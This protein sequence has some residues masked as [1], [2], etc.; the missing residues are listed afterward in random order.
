MTLVALASVVESISGRST[1]EKQLMRAVEV[2]PV[3]D[4]PGGSS[5]RIFLGKIAKFLKK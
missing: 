3:P 1:I 4:R 2:R 5:S